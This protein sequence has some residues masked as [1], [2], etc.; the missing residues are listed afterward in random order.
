VRAKSSI[1]PVLAL[2]L[3]AGLWSVPAEAALKI[4]VRGS[5]VL[6]ARATVASGGVQVRGQLA[7]DARRPIV[8]ERVRLR[9]REAPGGAPRRLPP[10]K[11]CDLT[12]HVHSARGDAVLPDEDVVD[13]DS[14]G[15]FCLSLPEATASG[16]IELE[17]QGT[18]YFAPTTLTI[19]VDA[20]RR[21][22]SLHFSPEPQRL[23][24]ERATHVIWVETQ[25]EPPFMATED[26]PPIQLALSFAEGNGAPK[27]L[28]RAIARPGE[29]VELTVESR[30][31]GEPG[32]GV[33]SVRFA[34]SDAVQPAERS[35]LVQRT[36]RVTLTVA[37][38]VAR[39]DPQ[40]GIEIPVA[41]A[42]ARG[43][44][45]AGA[46]EARVG[47]E[48]VG[49]A[50]VVGGMARVLAVFDAP[51]GGEVPLSLHYLP[52]APWWE[53][54]DA[55]TIGVQVSAPSPWRRLPWAIAVLL[56]AGWIIRGWYRPPRSEKPADDRQGLPAGR[57][58]VEVVEL[59]PAN[60]G[61][62]GRVLDA[63]DGTPIK[64][65]RVQILVPAFGGDGVAAETV[66]DLAGRF[67]LP[68]VAVVEGSRL[69]AGAPWHATLVKPVPPAGEVSINLVT[70]RRALLE[71]LVEWANQRGQPWKSEVEPTPANIARLGRRRR[72]PEVVRWAEQVEE[73]AYGPI[74]LD[75]Q[76]EREVR[77]REPHWGPEST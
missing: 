41:V 27:P 2:A 53:P 10:A 76:K 40:Q 26:A 17:F 22:L 71:R 59:G 15:H 62:R 28:A 12:D 5:A 50:P 7:D 16:V 11:A 46:I 8:A 60:S 24:L 74:E 19:P 44:V 58:S 20:S 65:A 3:G 29:R 47:N 33:L 35:A 38:R 55:L 72:S 75:E 66:S 67:E 77:S 73:A 36:A 63:H 70:R 13:S 18:Q 64:G 43:A 57:P 68:A 54:G 9:W 6:E 32:P 25:A 37:G 49:T 21:A 34:G 42:S 45:P 56:I 4:R 52:A 61:W 69:E 48:S 39:A 1:G 31:L 23:S 51:Q 14:T 30:A